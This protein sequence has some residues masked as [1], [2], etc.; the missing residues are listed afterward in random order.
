MSEITQD[1]EMHSEH[2]QSVLNREAAEQFAAAFSPALNVVAC[3]NINNQ[4][5]RHGFFVATHDPETEIGV[6][7]FFY[8]KGH[9]RAFVEVN[10]YI[11][12]AAEIGT[13]MERA[14]NPRVG[15]GVR[16]MKRPENT[17]KHDG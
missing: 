14:I 7:A 6:S 5:V 10:G 11:A 9:F 2:P 15:Y 12:R 8:G 13:M 16:H 4:P 3:Q 17:L 1:A